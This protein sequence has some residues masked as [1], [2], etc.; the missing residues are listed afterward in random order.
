MYYTY[1]INVNFVLLQK[2][3]KDNGNL[4]SGDFERNFFPTL[5]SSAFHENIKLLL[6]KLFGLKLK[7]SMMYIFCVLLKM[8]MLHPTLDSRLTF[9]EYIKRLIEEIYSTHISPCLPR[10]I[11]RT[12]CESLIRLH[13]N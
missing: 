10:S 2:N 8:E 1:S 3:P 5:L 9:N 11:S 7:Y 13:R 4:I 12:I 6:I